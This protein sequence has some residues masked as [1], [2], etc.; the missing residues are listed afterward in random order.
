MVQVYGARSFSA[1]PYAGT[2]F[3]KWAHGPYM[4]LLLVSGSCKRMSN[5]NQRRPRRCVKLAPPS[6]VRFMHSSF[7]ACLS[8]GLRAFSK[9]LSPSF[10]PRRPEHSRVP[11]APPAGLGR[12]VPPCVYRPRQTM[13]T[14]LKCR[15]H[16]RNA[17]FACSMDSPAIEPDTSTRKTTARRLDVFCASKRSGTNFKANVPSSPDFYRKPRRP[18]YPVHLRRRARCRD[19]APRFAR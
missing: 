19:R 12:A 4:A 9:A 8:C 17:R 13:R 10:E 14:S 16:S 11:V 2:T 6:N 15:K 1:G 3:A 7:Q 5:Q 18:R